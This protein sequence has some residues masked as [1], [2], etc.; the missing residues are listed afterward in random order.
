MS[1]T[2]QIKGKLRAPNRNPALQ[3]ELDR[4]VPVEYVMQWFREREAKIGIE[5]RFLVLKSGTGSGKTVTIPAE[6]YV[7]F[8][9]GKPSARRII[10]TQPR[11][12]TTK[13]SVR[14]IVSIPRYQSY[15]V[16]GQTIGW[17]TQFSK[18]RMRKHGLL[19]AT[20][21]TLTTQLN[22]ASNDE[23]IMATYKFIVIDEAHERSLGAD[24]L[25]ALLKGF[26]LRNAGNVRCPFVVLMSAT[27]DPQKF[28]RYFLAPGITSDPG[29]DL[30]N[31]I[32]ICD[33]SPAFERK[34][35]YA[36]EPVPNLIAESVHIVGQIMDSE[37]VPRAN[38]SADEGDAD[39]PRAP[40]RNDILIFVPGVD[41]IK[42]LA[43]AFEIFNK[44]R[45]E[46]NKTT[47]CVVPLDSQAVNLES[48][49]YINLSRPMREAYGNHERRVIISTNVAETGKTFASLRHV[50][51]FGYSR[52]SEFNPNIGAT[53]LISK[54]A[55]LSRIEQRAGRVARRFPGV[56]HHLYTAETA[57]KLP[58]Q[59]PPEIIVS[60][61]SS[62]ILSV[63]FEQ[64][65]SKFNSKREPYF[66]IEDMDLLD[67]PHP[68][69][70]AAAL[71]SARVLGF[72][73][74]DPP[75][76]SLEF[77]AF[78]S[79]TKR[80]GV[81][82]IGL[83]K[84]GRVA[85]A[86][87]EHFRSLKYLRFVL[88]GYTHGYK[89]AELIMVAI[90][91][92]IISSASLNAAGAE[93]PVDMSAI[94]NDALEPTADPSSP[95]TERLWVAILGDTFIQGALVA[96]IVESIYRGNTDDAVVQV[97]EWCA[98]RRVSVD[99]VMLILEKYYQACSCFLELGFDITDGLSVLDIVRKAN[100]SGAP[101]C[102][103]ELSRAIVCYKKCLYDGFRQ[104]LVTWSDERNTYITSS[105]IQITPGLIERA[106][107]CRPYAVILDNFNARAKPGK[108]VAEFSI[109]G[110]FVSVLSGYIGHDELFL[111]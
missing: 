76:F 11:V 52:E 31:N 98:D 86:L 93:E 17:S 5:N 45:A 28:A 94:Y 23:D 83:T 69:A 65:R 99:S 42:T 80:A 22:T 2:L 64:Q 14:D 71:E 74:R 77:S 33:S 40:D 75:V 37:P 111:Q 82:H 27:I 7:N 79:E 73:A 59:Q 47:A 12:L 92:M 108:D 38:W 55:P 101:P 8:I 53:L 36:Q 97:Q 19:M 25:Y 34:I 105:G 70:L 21:T 110:K 60:D 26:L 50:L 63:I 107:N 44:E 35:L 91:A 43:T 106:V 84:M 72:I 66:R 90:S 41:E 89:V 4:H 67:F 104:N 103:V 88:A 57:G 48:P 85:I 46:R 56:V 20:N 30:S 32:I 9:H 87:W 81:A 54:P 58:Q 68:D 96:T 16:L 13:D 10:C 102:P 3:R 62:V 51:D 24:L 100:D 78:M 15:L 109:A 29:A 1:Y 95:D 49:G 39:T 6:I 61:I 18:L